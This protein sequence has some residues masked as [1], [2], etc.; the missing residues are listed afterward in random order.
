MYVVDGQHDVLVLGHCEAVREGVLA[1]SPPQQHGRVRV[2]P[3]ALVDAPQRV[4]E[5]LVLLQV[6]RYGVSHHSI[7]FFLQNK[8][9]FLVSDATS[10]CHLIYSVKAYWSYVH[11]ETGICH[12]LYL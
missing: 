2:Q 12:T 4:L 6:R 10:S 1:Q 11:F 3:H 8:H 9:E 7:Y 5:L